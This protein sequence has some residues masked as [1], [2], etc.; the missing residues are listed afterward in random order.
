MTIS[1]CKNKL[2]IED[3]ISSSHFM[4]VNQDSAV[5]EFPDYMRGKIAVMGFI[6]TN[7][8][9]ICPLT[10][11]NMQRI[12]AEL[13]KENIKDVLFTSL[14]FDPARDKPFVLKDYARI[15]NIDLKNWQFLTG[16]QSVIDSIKK[17]MHFF[18][19]AADTSYSEDG[20][21]YYF[22]VHTDRISLIDRQ[23]RVR[24]NYKGSTINIGEIVNDIKQIM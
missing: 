2:P 24:K 17:K 14:S 3:D 8:P 22:F 19:V 18:A 23:G 13:E 1:G 20:K 16:K 10:T 12:K 15:R 5:V 21:K 7:C 6:F 11:N 9:D 4:L